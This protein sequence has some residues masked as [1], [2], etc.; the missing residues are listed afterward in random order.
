MVDQGRSQ[1]LGAGERWYR[2]RPLL[3]DVL[4][5]SDNA[6][7]QREEISRLG[8]LELVPLSEKNRFRLIGSS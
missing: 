5:P 7:G 1:G 6:R 3:Q 4:L 2:V 8:F